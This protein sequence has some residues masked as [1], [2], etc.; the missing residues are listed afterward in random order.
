M[1]VADLMRLL[2]ACDPDAVVL[3]PRDGCLDDP[4]EV[5]TDVVPVSPSVFATGP[6]AIHGAVRLAGITATVIVAKG[7]AAGGVRRA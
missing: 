5:L 3:I 6:A 2:E 7:L 4:A 1:I